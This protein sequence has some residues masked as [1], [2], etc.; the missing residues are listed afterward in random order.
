MLMG[1]LKSIHDRYSYTGF[2]ASTTHV[3]LAALN[4]KKKICGAGARP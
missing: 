1:S 4:R 2:L 3:V